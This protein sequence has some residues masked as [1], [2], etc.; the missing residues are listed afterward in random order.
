MGPDAMILVSKYW[1]LSRLFHSPLSPSSR[2]CLALLHF[3]PMERYHLHI[4]GDISP[5]NMCVCVCVCVLLVSLLKHSYY[6]HPCTYSLIQVDRYIFLLGT[7]L[8]NWNSEFYVMCMFWFNRY[9]Q[10]FS[11][12]IVSMCTSTSKIRGLLLFHILAYAFLSFVIL[13]FE[14]LCHGMLL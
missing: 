7:S 6:K 10:Q 4:W 8:N 5:S 13:P 1:I 12:V 14:W 2:V 11:K 3:L 9:C